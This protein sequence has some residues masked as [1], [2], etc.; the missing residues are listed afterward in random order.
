[1][2]HIDKAKSTAALVGIIVC[3]LVVIGGQAACTY[4]A[5]P[6][7]NAATKAAPPMITG[8]LQLSGLLNANGATKADLR[9]VSEDGLALLRLAKGTRVLDAQK[10]PG[11]SVQV[12]AWQPAL[13]RDIAYAGQA[14]RFSP[15]GSPLNQP[16]TL[17]LD[18]DPKVYYPFRFPGADCTH[19]HIAFLIDDVHVKPIQDAQ[20]D[21]QTHSVTAR[22]DHLGAFVLYCD[23][24]AQPPSF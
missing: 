24:I 12:T 7:A 9:L 16:A 1:M 8:V 4:A 13:R 22:I 5:T 15:D 2:D 14:Y 3:G 11:E 20:V 17:V 19:L 6:A 18:F 23:V 21:Q 10:R